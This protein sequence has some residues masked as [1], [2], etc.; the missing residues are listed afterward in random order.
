MKFTTKLLFVILFLFAGNTLTAKAQVISSDP[1]L[2]KKEIKAENSLQKAKV[3]LEKSQA[4]LLNLRN[5]YDKKRKKFEKQNS[6]G[7][8]SPRAVSSHTK[9][10]NNLSKKIS[11][12]LTTIQKLEK[13]I[14]S[15]EIQP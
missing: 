11:K 8:L 5:E 6:K 4:R 1:E 10:L 14:L 7:K 9:I 3:D 15:N 12:E 13:Y 2:S